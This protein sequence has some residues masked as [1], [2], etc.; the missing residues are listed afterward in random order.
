[1]QV[2]RSTDGLPYFKNAVVTIGT[3]DGV[4]AGHQK[5]IAALQAEA[6]RVNGETVIITFN[7]HPRR[8]VQPQKPLQLLNTLEEK[9]ALLES[10]AINHLVVVPFT[11]AFSEQAANEYI[12]SFLIKNFNPASIIIGYDHHFGKDRSGNYKLL[13]EK[14]AEFSYHLIEIPQHVLN[15]IEVSSTKI[16]NAIL[17]SDVET[18]NR[19]LGYPFFFQGKVVKGDQLGRT[20]GYPTANL[21]YADA[22]KIRLGHGVYA[23]Y[24]TIRGQQK[25]GMMSIGTRPT[26]DKREEK[27]EVNVFDFEGDLYGQY[28]HVTV[29]NFLRPQEKYSS[30]KEMIK[31][32]HKD[33]VKSMQVL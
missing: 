11:A 1:M 25:K 29:K 4:H 9:I 28:L 8:I 33:K 21:E 7:P 13:E 31:Q 18:A 10:A 14:A 6:A 22:E 26:L 19:L 23:V 27:V 16:R 12:E 5:I 17:S 2:H 30:L 20:L 32:L 15:E 3:F 24:V